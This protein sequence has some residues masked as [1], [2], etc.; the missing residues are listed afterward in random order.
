M[1]KRGTSKAE[2]RGILKK[3]RVS[4]AT[5]LLERWSEA[6]GSSGE[7]SGKYSQQ[8][9]EPQSRLTKCASDE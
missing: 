8:S 3:E 6:H 2:R 9:V 4:M 5:V 7:T 1:P